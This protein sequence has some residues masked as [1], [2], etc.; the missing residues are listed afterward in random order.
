MKNLLTAN[1]KIWEN[2]DD[3]IEKREEENILGMEEDEVQVDG[4][5]KKKKVKERINT[6]AESNYK[7]RYSCMCVKKQDGSDEKVFYGDTAVSEFAE[8]M[9]DLKQVIFIAHNIRDMMDIL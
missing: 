2:E 5:V 3:N 8:W 6:K 9:L 4:G 7:H 1:V